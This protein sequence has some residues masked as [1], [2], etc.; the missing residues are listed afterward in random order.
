MTGQPLSILFLCTANSA[1]SI[2][3][4]AIMNRL[5][6]GRI[7]AYSAGSAP[8]GTV[9]PMS[10]ELLQSKGYPTDAA[11][12]KSWDEFAGPDAPH[13]D[14]IVTVCDNAAGEVCPVWPGHPVQIHWGFP[15]PAAASGSADEQRAC[16]EDVFDSIRRRLESALPI[17]SEPFDPAT[18]KRCLQTVAERAV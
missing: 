9:H 8:G 16:F 13:M 18:V 11:R 3:A 1:R 5:G 14:I 2:L 7:R 4:E 6:A 17:L 12:S 15:D 10:L